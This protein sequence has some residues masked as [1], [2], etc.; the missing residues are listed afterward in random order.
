MLNIVA[1]ALLVIA[2]VGRFIV[3]QRSVTIIKVDSILAIE[4]KALVIVLAIVRAAENTLPMAL[5]EVDPFQEGHG[6]IIEIGVENA[7]IDHRRE[8]L[9]VCTML[10]RQFDVARVVNR[11]I[12]WIDEIALVRTVKLGRC[13]TTRLVIRFGC[14]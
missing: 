2:H 5:N 4:L 12:V 1:Q 9:I 11:W 14:R 8:D 13:D 7:M 6:R 3:D 10:H